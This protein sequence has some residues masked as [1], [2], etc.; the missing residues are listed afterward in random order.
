MAVI[1][2]MVE[3]AIAVLRDGKLSSEAIREYHERIQILSEPQVPALLAESPDSKAPAPIVCCPLEG[4]GEGP[5][6]RSGI[7]LFVLHIQ[8]GRGLPVVKEFFVDR[9]PLDSV[10]ESVPT[11]DSFPQ[12]D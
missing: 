7:E 3:F 5:S 9:S 12:S 1:Y 2:P 8:V 4:E 10:S 11:K 6:H